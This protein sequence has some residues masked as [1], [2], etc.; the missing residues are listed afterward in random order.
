M[1][2][3]AVARSH[4]GE[5]SG[6]QAEKS[7]LLPRSLQ[8]PRDPVS[9]AK[10]VTSMQL[11]LSIWE[12]AYFWQKECCPGFS[13]CGCSGAQLASFVRAVPH[14][15]RGVQLIQACVHLDTLRNVM[16]ADDGHS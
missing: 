2:E 5:E 10:K 4:P 13:L 7:G 14:V 9:A 16:H 12:S 15:M 11:Q 1:L 3:A 8:F 6:Q